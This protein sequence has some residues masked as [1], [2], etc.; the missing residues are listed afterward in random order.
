MDK[1]LGIYFGAKVFI[2]FLI[3]KPYHFLIGCKSTVE[4]RDSYVFFVGYKE[5]QFSYLA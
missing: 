5:V 4:L 1:P 3:L 2:L